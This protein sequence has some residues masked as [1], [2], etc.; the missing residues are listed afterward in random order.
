MDIRPLREDMHSLTKRLSREGDTGVVLGDEGW[1]V[2]DGGW[3][4]TQNT[5]V[6]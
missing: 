4:A 2:E 3:R 6:T 1:R 5:S